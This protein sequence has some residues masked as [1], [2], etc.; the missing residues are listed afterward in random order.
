MVRTEFINTF[1]NPTEDEIGTHWTPIAFDMD[2]VLNQGDYLRE[3][4]IR[5]F[6]ASG[7]IRERGPEGYIKFNYHVEGV[8]RNQMY[9][10][11]HQGVYEES[12]SSLPSPFMAQVLKYVHEITEQPIAV[13]TARAN[14]NAGVTYRW[15]MENL[16]GTPFKVY[17]MHG[18]P[19]LGVIEAL[20]ADIFIDDRWK[21]VN[22]LG[23]YIPY[24]ILFKQEWNQGR[25][26]PAGSF[27]IRDLRDIIPLVNIHR[28]RNPMDWPAGLPYPKPMGERI[29][30]KYAT[31]L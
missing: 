31:I 8:S 27:E 26:K 17:V 13:I 9:K 28:G 20:G 29:T 1:I 3:Y 6:G 5:H 14:T 11:I 15:L 10:A 21:T 22:S 18:V 7:D 16:D 25:P 23:G 19:K 2:S 30:K 24:P 4:I 12:P